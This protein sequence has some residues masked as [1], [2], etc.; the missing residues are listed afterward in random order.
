MTG[1]KQCVFQTFLA[2]LFGCRMG[3]GNAAGNNW[4]AK[5]GFP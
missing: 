1:R 2:V 3:P 5:D 4:V